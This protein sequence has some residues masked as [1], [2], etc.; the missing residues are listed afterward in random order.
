MR[1]FIHDFLKWFPTAVFGGSI[2]VSAVWV[3]ARD[4]IAAQAVWVWS[5]MNDPR[6]A[7][8]V[9]VALIVYVAAVIWSGNKDGQGSGDTHIH[10]HY[11][12]LPEK[13]EQTVTKAPAVFLFNRMIVFMHTPAA[14][15]TRGFLI[16]QEQQLP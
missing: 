15:L 3:P 9:V 4:W 16:L 2:A 7:F 5:A 11:Q 10:H 8:F 1:Q 6:I 12:S 13:L 14:L